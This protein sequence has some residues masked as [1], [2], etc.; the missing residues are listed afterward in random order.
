MAP[1]VPGSALVKGSGPPCE[2][3]GSASPWA[4]ILD[5]KGSASDMLF[6]LELKGSLAVVAVA[7]APLDWEPKGSGAAAVL[8]SWVANGSGSGAPPAPPKGS[9]EPNGSA[10]G[11]GAA[12]AGACLKKE[13]AANGSLPLKGSPP[14]GSEMVHKTET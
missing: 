3:K 7:V 11:K 4:A 6:A 10:E 1:S 13:S 14:K 8:L 2:L 12:V 5:A 9:T